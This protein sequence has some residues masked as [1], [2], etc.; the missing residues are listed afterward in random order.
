MKCV[1]VFTRIPNNYAAHES[2]Y[3]ILESEPRASR[4]LIIPKPSALSASFLIKSI[5]DIV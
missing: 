5:Y 2:A 3:S 1:C 4:E